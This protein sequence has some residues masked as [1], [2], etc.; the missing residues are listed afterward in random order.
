MRV[1]QGPITGL[2]VFSVVFSWASCVTTPADAGGKYNRRL[3]VGDLAPSFD[4][5]P[6]TDG[7]MIATSDFEAAKVLVVVFTCNSCPYSVD[8]EDRLNAFQT[9]Y[10]TATSEN[11]APQVQLVAIN[12]NLVSAD[13]PDQMKARAEQKGFRFPYLFDASQQVP[14]AY[15]AVRTPEFFVLNQERRVVYMGTFDDNAN[16]K[17]V[18]HRFVQSAV[19]AT[20]RDEPVEVSETAPVG[21]MIRFKRNRK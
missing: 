21:C 18:K 7:R 9:E 15:G 20:L 10:C 1:P 2:V 8:Y 3:A 14:Q 11:A 6:A 16:P 12:S 13:L 19:Q 5:L 17:E 4:A